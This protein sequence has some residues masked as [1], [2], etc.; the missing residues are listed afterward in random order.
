MRTQEAFCAFSSSYGERFRPSPPLVL[1]R[2]SS[3]RIE[4]WR[5]SGARLGCKAVPDDAGSTIV[6]DALS[7]RGKMQT[8]SAIIIPRTISPMGSVDRVQVGSLPVLQGR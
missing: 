8:E 3:E 5:R 1:Q 2:T 6:F 7:K 4:N